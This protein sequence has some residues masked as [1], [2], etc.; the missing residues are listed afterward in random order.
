MRMLTIL[1]AGCLTALTGCGEKEKDIA[2]NTVRLMPMDSKIVRRGESIYAQT[3]ASCHGLNLQG[4]ENWKVRNQQGLL[5]APPH[6]ETGHTWH[7]ADQYLF[8][9]TKFGVQKYA[10]ADYKSTMPAYADTLSDAEIIAVLSYIKSQWPDS[11]RSRHDGVNAQYEAL[12]EHQD[13]K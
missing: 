13:K 8:D 3:C 1:F 10:G 9:I 6:D 12:L 4:Q 7:H 2:S 5:P 11:V